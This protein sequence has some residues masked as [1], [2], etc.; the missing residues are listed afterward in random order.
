MVLLVTTAENSGIDRYSQELAK[1]VGVPTVESRR[2]LSLKDSLHLI[3]RLRQS[4]YPI[5]FTRQHF[6]RH[7]LFLGKPFIITVHDL[8]RICFPFAAEAVREKVGPKLDA[9]GLK[10]AQHIIAV[11]AHTK[12]DLLRYLKIPEDKITVVHNG[13]DHSTFKP[14][15]GKSA[16]TRKS[17]S[18]SRTQVILT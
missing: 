12:G 1:R 10:K 11:S 16:S 13:V 8:V 7:G 18:Q 4:P 5:H 9:L 17:L 15:P 3:R 2:Y 6:G 14:A